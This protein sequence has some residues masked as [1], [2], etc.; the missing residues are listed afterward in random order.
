MYSV[1]YAECHIQVLY[2]ECNYGEC[3]YDK[4]HDANCRYDKC[5]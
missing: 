1:S 5:R 2:A 3:C 4:C